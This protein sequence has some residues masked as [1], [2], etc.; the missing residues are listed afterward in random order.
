MA[1]EEETL[2]T[3]TLGIER[4]VQFSFIGGALVFFWMLDHLLA[5]VAD[6]V[7][8]KANMAELPP[9]AVTAIAA[10]GGI[11][12]AWAMYQNPKINRFSRE[13]AVELARVTW[14]TRKET[15]NNTVIVLIVSVVAAVILG[16]MDALW[17][18]LSD[19]VY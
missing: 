6:W 16:V 7:T 19:F 18:T 13:V 12:G 15:T 9:T 2:P 11:A 8:R 3:G 4:W 1:M 5:N 14:P 17:S 10:V